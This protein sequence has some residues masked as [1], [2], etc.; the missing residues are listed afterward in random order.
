VTLSKVKGGNVK[1][2][3]ALFLVAFSVACGAKKVNPAIPVTTLQDQM[4]VE[5]DRIKPNLNW[6]NGFAVNFECN[7]GDSHYRT[8]QLFLLGAFNEQKEAAFASYVA[9]I[10]ED[11]RPWRGP[12]KDETPNSYSSDQALGLVMATIGGLD[13]GVLKKVYGYTLAHSRKFCPDATDLRCVMKPSL[14][15]I[16]RDTLGLPVD[17]IMRELSNVQILADAYTTTPNFRAALILQQIMV[18]IKQNRATEVHRKVMNILRTKIPNNLYFRTIDTMINGGD[19]N[20]IAERVLACMKVNNG[21]GIHALFEQG[22][23]EC[24]EGVYGQEL[25]ALAGFLG[26]SSFHAPIVLESFCD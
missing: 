11:G 26:N 16:I 7:T 6:C 13:K 1:K 8:G 18:K 12:A 17:G 19:F 2:V 14:E 24:R 9:S 20:P 25:I 10:D 4:Q 3:L 21:G 22:N 15:V 23:N 5:I